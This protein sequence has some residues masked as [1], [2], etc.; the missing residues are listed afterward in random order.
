MS[1]ARLPQLNPEVWVICDKD[2]YD[3]ILARGAQGDARSFLTAR[4]R[5]GLVRFLAEQAL[6]EKLAPLCSSAELVHVYSSDLDG[7]FDRASEA[8]LTSS[9]GGNVRWHR[10]NDG[11]DLLAHL[12]DPELAQI[13]EWEDAA[14]PWTHTTAEPRHEAFT[15]LDCAFNAWLQAKREA[16]GGRVAL[17]RALGIE[18]ETGIVCRFPAI[19]PATG[20][21]RSSRDADGQDAL[22]A[23]AASGTENADDP[24][25]FWRDQIARDGSRWRLSI[26]HDGP[27]YR[28]MRVDLVALGHSEGEFGEHFEAATNVVRA[29]K[30]VDTI[31]AQWWACEMRRTQDPNKSL[32]G[33]VSE[34]T[35]AEFEQMRDGIVEV[36]FELSYAYD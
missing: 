14:L 23:A 9:D 10:I 22:R 18:L 30:R 27:D 21:L 8:D 11:V 31:A 34:V 13:A 29:F 24:H 15:T 17:A 19:K 3:D 4:T 5:C 25:V 1:D 36:E 35:W 32:T 12:G 6:F 33:D 26:E 28:Q 20:E 16:Y 7:L 2:V